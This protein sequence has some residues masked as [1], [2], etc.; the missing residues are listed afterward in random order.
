MHSIGV[1]KVS[2]VQRYD[3]ERAEWQTVSVWE[4]GLVGE[5]FAISPGDLGKQA[6]SIVEV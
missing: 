2:C 1:D 3:C 6:L 4:G 5:D